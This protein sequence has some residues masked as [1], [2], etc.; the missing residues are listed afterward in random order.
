[1][2][3]LLASALLGFFLGGLPFGLWIG[4][5]R[6]VELTERGSRNIGATNAYRVLGPAIGVAVFLLD[7]AKGALA[8]LVT[9]W[10]PFESGVPALALAIVAGVAAVLGHM[11]TPWARFRG[12]KG[13][14]TSLG[15]FL[16]I[17]PLPTLVAF[18]LWIVLF[19]IG[20]FRVSLGSIGAAIAYPFLVWF[21]APKDGRLVLTA[22]SA[23]IAAF[24]VFRHKTNIRRLLAGAEPP[25]VRKRGETPR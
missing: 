25:L 23:A 22:V 13:V 10:L 4:R 20:G 19:L 12:G 9:H 2:L 15:V 1:M 8:V 3:K 21:L 6:G 17:V 11:L 7:T 5:V 16:A 14:A 18:C 24:V